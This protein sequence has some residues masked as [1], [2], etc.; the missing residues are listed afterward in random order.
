MRELLFADLPPLTALERFAA[1]EPMRSLA[2]A[3]L[4][5]DGAAARDRLG[6]LLAAGETRVRLQAWSIGR[7]A[8][9]EPPVETAHVAR[10]VVV[11]VG[12]E[13][14]TD[15]I[16]AY[17]DG[18]ARYLNQAGGAI[19]WD[20][21]D[22]AIDEAVRTLLAAAQVIA[23]ASGP[24]DGP[25]PSAPDQGYGSIWVLTEAGIHAGSGPFGTLAANRLGGPVVGAAIDLM[26]LLIER[27]EAAPPS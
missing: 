27:S 2:E 11:E 22:A 7:A 16:A 4:R 24:L 18:S 9:L 12:L 10:G 19:V 26:R 17:D 3:A 13:L 15:T 14:G 1:V 6:T 5:E 23:D 20:T 25:R 8:G 21:R